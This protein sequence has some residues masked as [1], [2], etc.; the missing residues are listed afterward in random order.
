MK[1]MLKVIT[2]DYWCMCTAFLSNGELWLLHADLPDEIQE[3]LPKSAERRDAPV[4]DKDRTFVK[5]KDVIAVAPDW[6]PAIEAELADLIAQVKPIEQ[7][8]EEYMR[9]SE[10][11]LRWAEE[12][13]PDEGDIE[14]AM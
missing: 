3:L 6:K 9:S 5:A 8:H 2:N 13:W 4:Y 11:H 12:M 14:E 1:L 10:G 7:H